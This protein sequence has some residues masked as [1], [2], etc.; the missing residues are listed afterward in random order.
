MAPEGRKGLCTCLEVAKTVSVQVLPRW[1]H[2]CRHHCSEKP[3]T[4]DPTGCFRRPPTGPAV[5][6]NMSSTSSL[7]LMKMPS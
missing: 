3:F 4:P 2:P 7:A 1:H 5:L 6:L